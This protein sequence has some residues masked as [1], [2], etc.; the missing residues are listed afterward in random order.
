MHEVRPRL[1]W[2]VDEMRGK[3]AAE[4]NQQ[5]SDWRDVD[6]VVLLRML[7][8][9]CD[10]V[11]AALVSGDPGH[12]VWECADVANVAM[13]LAD[14]VGRPRAARSQP[15]T[16]STPLGTDLPPGPA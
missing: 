12:V 15:R 11:R 2:F 8:A 7:E 4:R 1:D 14:R 3:L 9:E 13:M 16:P 5:K 10:E 6:P